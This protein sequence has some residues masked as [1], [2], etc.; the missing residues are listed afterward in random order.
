MENNIPSHFPSHSLN[1][2]SSQPPT[3][4]HPQVSPPTS[5]HLPTR[6]FPTHH[7]LTSWSSTS[8]SCSWSWP[9]SSTGRPATPANTASRRPPTRGNYTGRWSPRPWCEMGIRGGGLM[10]KIQG[11][12]HC[13]GI[14]HYIRNSIQACSGSIQ[15]W[16]FISDGTMSMAQLY[17]G[18]SREQL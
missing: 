17:I 5:L 3:H 9:S 1:S 14:Y 7:P 4:P 6:P 10:S 13:P 2:A 16:G 12:T 15:S 18:P 8:W 11:W